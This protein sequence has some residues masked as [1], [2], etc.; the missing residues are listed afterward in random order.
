MYSLLLG[1][2]S[3]F[4]LPAAKAGDDKPL[5]SA[6]VPSAAVKARLSLRGVN[7]SGN[8]KRLF[9]R[10]NLAAD[11]CMF[12]FKNLLKIIKYFINC[13]LYHNNS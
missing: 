5:P 3:Q 1:H 13:C 4:K 9:L 7:V 2:P 10:W 11:D 6:S 8:V 12:I